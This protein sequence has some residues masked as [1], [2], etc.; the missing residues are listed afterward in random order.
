M[1]AY[2]LVRVGDL[3]WRGVLGSLASLD[4][5]SVMT[6]AELALVAAPAVMIWQGR[7][8]P[9]LGTLTRA[10]LLMLAAGTVYRF[11]TYLLAFQPGAHWS[12]FPGVLEISVT[13]GIFSFEVLAYITIVH[14]FPALRAEA[15]PS[16]AREAHA[17][18]R[19]A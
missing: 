1:G 12:Y 6:W 13:A 5:F 3:A 15:I 17:A 16:G 14:W 7:R 19:H 4:V 8:R 2:L 9:R 10:A 11:D 18:G